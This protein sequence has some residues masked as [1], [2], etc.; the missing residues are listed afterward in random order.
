MDCHE[1]WECLF[2]I[3]WLQRQATTECGKFP[4]EDLKETASQLLELLK[5]C[6]RGTQERGHKGFW[7][8]RRGFAASILSPS[9]IVVKGL[10]LRNPE[11]TLGN[12]E[13]TLRNPEG[14]LGNP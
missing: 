1:D 5:L 7:E 3:S 2:G 12:P 8:Q 10:V 4:G 14:T 6:S 13:G 9:W 11:G